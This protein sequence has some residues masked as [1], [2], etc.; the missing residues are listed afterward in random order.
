MCQ[1]IPAN[2]I[3]A[4]LLLPIQDN[5]QHPLCT[6]QYLRLALQ[7]RAWASDPP[8]HRITAQQS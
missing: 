7:H 6:N 3:A 5:L 4:G 8:V 2:V 1:C